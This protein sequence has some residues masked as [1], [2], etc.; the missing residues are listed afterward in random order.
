MKHIVVVLSLLIASSSVLAD[1]PAANPSDVGAAIDRG[2]AFLAKDALAWKKEHNCASC[3]HAAFVVWAMQE[4]KQRGHAVDETILADMTK[5]VAEAGDGTTS[6]KRPDNAPKAFNSKALYFSLALSAVPNKDA[7][8]QEAFARLFNTVKSDQTEN[9]SWS[10]WPETRPP[11]FGDSDEALTILE[12]L[13]VLHAADAGDEAAKTVRDK[14]VHWLAET[15]PGDDPQAIAMR[16]VLW[17]RLG[18]PAEEWLPLVERIKSNQN[19]DGGWSQTK[20]M[21]SDAWATGQALYALAHA[22]LQPE[23]PAVA[24]GR[25]FLVQVQRDVGSWPMTSRPTKPGDKGSKSLIPITAAG[26]AWGVIG[27]AR[28]R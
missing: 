1:E 14:G 23:N 13:T 6:L 12:T 17:Q 15:K 7:A 10:A 16:V 4:A 11:I 18:R 26:S 21:P 28:S 8:T 24:R 27:L 5:W 2:L 20:E 25:A 3:H 9:G 19:G 22:G